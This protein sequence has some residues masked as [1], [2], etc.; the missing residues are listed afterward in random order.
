MRADRRMDAL[1]DLAEPGI[2]Q[3][4]ALPLQVLDR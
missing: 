1:L 2:E 3:P 4:L